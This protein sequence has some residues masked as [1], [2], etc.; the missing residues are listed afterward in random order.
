MTMS[1][2]RPMALYRSGGGP[3]ALPAPESRRRA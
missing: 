2:A 1:Q 3:L